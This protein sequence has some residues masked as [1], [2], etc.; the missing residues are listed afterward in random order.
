MAW[1]A[2]LENGVHSLAEAV[3]AFETF[4]GDSTNAFTLEDAILRS[5]H[6]LETL[7]KLLL[8]GTELGVALSRRHDY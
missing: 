8:L 7:F 4:H 6:A 3:R 5:H 2:P 1:I